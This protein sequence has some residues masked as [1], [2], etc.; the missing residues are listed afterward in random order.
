[1][2]DKVGGAVEG[3]TR[4]GFID[5]QKMDANHAREVE[6]AVEAQLPAEVLQIIDREYAGG[7]C[8]RCSVGWAPV[9]VRNRF[10]DFVYY[11]P[12]CICYPRC[13]GIDAW[14]GVLYW[15]I[16]E[17]GKRRVVSEKPVGKRAQKRTKRVHVMH[18]QT[19]RK[20]KPIPQK[21]NELVAREFA[22]TGQVMCDECQRQHEYWTARGRDDS[23]PR[24]EAS[25]DFNAAMRD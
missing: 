6:A 20:G 1:M 14:Y 10:A 18:P 19:L 12:A 15:V 8:P 23:R 4:A 11:Q 5:Q 7:P 13:P 2:S 22:L 24:E 9:E 17:D 21:C 25:T 16:T 3:L